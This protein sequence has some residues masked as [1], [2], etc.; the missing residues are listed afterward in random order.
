[1]LCDCLEEGAECKGTAPLPHITNPDAGWTLSG[2]ATLGLV[3]TSML[4][5]SLAFL[6]GMGLGRF[7]QFDGKRYCGVRSGDTHAVLNVAIAMVAWPAACFGMAGLG[8]AANWQSRWIRGGCQNFITLGDDD[9]TDDIAPEEVH[10]RSPVL[11]PGLITGM[12]CLLGIACGLAIFFGRRT[13]L[14]SEELRKYDN[15]AG[16]YSDD[17]IAGE[18]PSPTGSVLVHQGG[19]DV[20]SRGIDCAPGAGN[21]VE[22]GVD[23]PDLGAGFSTEEGAV[24]ARRGDFES[25]AGQPDEEPGTGQVGV[26]RSP[27]RPPGPGPSLPLRAAVAHRALDLAKGPPGKSDAPS[28]RRALEHMPSDVRAILGRK[29]SLPTTEPP[30]VARR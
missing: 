15:A 21:D 14:R 30:G 3:I 2:S 1:L 4:L 29:D 5:M 8:V 25:R 9:P 7:V 27:L 10:F 13:G 28:A 22:M 18:E 26:S 6:G 24:L 17:I 23:R 12:G 20:G 11:Q 16:Q 19:E